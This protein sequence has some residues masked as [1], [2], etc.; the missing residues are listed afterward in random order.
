MSLMRQKISYA[1]GLFLLL[2]VLLG[3][4]SFLPIPFSPHSANI[5]Q[6]KLVLRPS[7]A[8][9]IIALDG[10]WMLTIPGEEARMQKVPSV[11]W[12]EGFGTYLLDLDWQ[13]ERTAFELY[14]IN[15]G[16]SFRLSVNDKVIGS[17]GE[18]GKDE[19]SSRPSAKPT[20]FSFDLLPGTNQIMIEVSNFV[21]PRAGLWEHILLGT[22]P[23]LCE[24]YQRSISLDFL[25]F[26]QVLLFAILQ[27]FLS[28]FSR[29]RNAYL[30]FALGA[31]FAAFGALMRNAFAIYILFPSID[32]LLLK[33]LQII[34]YY[35]ASGFFIQAFIEHVPSK[36]FLRLST[37]FLIFS[38]VLSAISFLFPFE[39]IY[40]IALGFFPVMLLFLLS[41]IW[42]QSRR[43]FS[44][45][46]ENRIEFLIPFFADILLCYGMLHDFICILQARYEYQ[47]IP[48]MIY[49]YVGLYSIVLAKQYVLANKQTEEA[50]NLI[51]RAS[52]REKRRIADDL[53]DGVGQL[54]HALEYL[55]QGALGSSDVNVSTLQTIRDTSAEA[56]GQL[57]NIIDDLNPVRYGTMGLASLL[58]TM[59]ERTQ[60]I[61]GC[62]VDC[63]IE[64]ESIKMDDLVAQQLYYLYSEA[65]KN[66]ITH[67]KPERIVVFLII[68]AD[69]II[70]SIENDG[71]LDAPLS[72]SY[73]GHGIAIMRYR[74]EQL[75]G[76]FSLSRDQEDRVTV[77]FQIQRRKI[78][79]SSR[80]G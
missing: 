3:T 8:F 26:G 31:I 32:Y 54:L 11:A 14:T 73:T 25:M 17:S 58:R 77:R 16:T 7:D 55:S 22:K 13:G 15:A 10:E 51:I 80:F 6:G 53:H 74:I 59:T 63:L 36:V 41:R 71:V 21:H 2:I 52:E 67:A 37:A 1:L 56:V 34:T 35:L 75:G 70:G 27:G 9:S 61:Y 33:R 19:A 24:Y 30:W 39:L 78:D 64:G 40:Q 45:E 44:I 79:D 68:K 65:I 46:V 57:Q 72:P 28:Y 20:V 18:Y 12:G 76:T 47:M 4:V 38:I 23:L 43:F 48:L 50:K 29:K 69:S 66:A 42:Q 49:V 60:S 5:S 62:R